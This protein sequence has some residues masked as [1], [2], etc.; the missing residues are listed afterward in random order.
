MAISLES[1][2]VSGLER[3]ASRYAV[4][5]SCGGEG[6][7]VGY[8]TT[9]STLDSRHKFGAPIAPSSL[10]NYS[11]VALKQQ[12][13]N[14]MFQRVKLLLKDQ[15]H[16]VLFYKYFR[17]F[18]N[19]LAYIFSNVPCTQNIFSV[20]TRAHRIT[21]QLNDIATPITCIWH[22]STACYILSTSATYSSLSA[23]LHLSQAPTSA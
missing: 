13:R 12:K 2:S 3:E 9:N 4:G 10:S 8:C 14:T 16:L 5:N 19:P 22:I 15:R 6:R 17:V 7:G 11:C 18:S 20:M 23:H 1:I 21:H